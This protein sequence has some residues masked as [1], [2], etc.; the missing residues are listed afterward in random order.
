MTPREADRRRLHALEGKARVRHPDPAPP[1]SELEVWAA[2]VSCEV[3]ERCERMCRV[4]ADDPGR[5]DSP[6]SEFERALIEVACQDADYGDADSVRRSYLAYRPRD[7]ADLSMATLRAQ[8]DDW[9]L[10]AERTFMHN[11]DVS[12]W[13]SWHGIIIDQLGP[14]ELTRL[15][16]LLRVFEDYPVEGAAISTAA[17]WA[18]I[19]EHGRCPRH[20]MV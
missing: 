13:L 17:T 1:P 20:G 15:A 4:M 14:G 6:L 19:G 8:I 2:T 7:L 11:V 18:S 10:G 9:I 3:L 5:D 16:A 12:G